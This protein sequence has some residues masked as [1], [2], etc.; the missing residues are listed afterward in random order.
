MQ[1]KIY[2]LNEASN[3]AIY[4]L[5]ILKIQFTE[6]ITGTWFSGTIIALMCIV[7][8]SGSY[9]QKKSHRLL[10]Y[11]WHDKLCL[12]PFLWFYYYFEKALVILSV[13]YA[14]FGYPVGNPFITFTVPLACGIYLGMKIA[15]YLIEYNVRKFVK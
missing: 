5:L 6:T 13:I 1:T 4:L 3:I 11:K 14:L 7:L 10:L 2:L 12:T 8:L 9:L 15:I